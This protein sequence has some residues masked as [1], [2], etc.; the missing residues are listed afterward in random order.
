MKHDS[1]DCVVSGPWWITPTHITP[2]HSLDHAPG[3]SGRCIDRTRPCGSSVMQRR[4]FEASGWYTTRCSSDCWTT[5]LRRSP[6]IGSSLPLYIGHFWEARP[7]A[8]GCIPCIITVLILFAMVMC[9]IC[10]VFF[11]SISGTTLGSICR[12]EAPLPA[13]Q[14]NRATGRGPPNASMRRNR[15]DTPA[16][17]SGTAASTNEEAVVFVARMANVRSRARQPLVAQLVHIL[18]PAPESPATPALQLASL[19]ALDVVIAACAP[20]MPRWKGTVLDGL[21]RRWVQLAASGTDSSGEFSRS[22]R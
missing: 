7:G 10:S 8:D 18:L 3:A 9:S 16:A 15:V 21:C 17:G 13:H 20:R 12:E 4:R 6:H 11:V 1:S 2:F 14:A 19:R 5:L 22:H